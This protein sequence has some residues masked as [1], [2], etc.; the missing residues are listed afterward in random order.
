LTTVLFIDMVGAGERVVAMGDRRW[1]E[2][3]AQYA[4]LIRQELA[5]HGGDEMNVV[6]DEVLAA[7]DGAAAAIRCGC[8][9][10]DAAKGLGVAV[11]IGIHAGEVEHD[12]I[13]GITVLTGVRIARKAQPGE[14][15]VSNTIKELVA[16]S[17]ITFIDRGT[18]ALKGLPGER[19]LFSPA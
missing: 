7:F 15:L 2:L 12:D 18:H 6:G 4:A 13:S 19:R 16:G 14:I 5:R 9:I 1:L 8:A 3:R 10:R 11:R 17:G